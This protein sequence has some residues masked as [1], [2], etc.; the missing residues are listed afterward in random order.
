MTIKLTDVGLAFTEYQF[1]VTVKNTPPYFLAIKP[2]DQV[3]RL[4]EELQYIL[5]PF[6]DD[7]GQLV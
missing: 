3:V 7:E 1:I 6:T 4:N 2:K 5:P